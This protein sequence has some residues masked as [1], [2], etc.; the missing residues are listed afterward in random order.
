M[1]VERL[2]ERLRRWLAGLAR[3]GVQLCEQRA[4]ARLTAHHD[5]AE[6]ARAL[7]VQCLSA[8]QRDEFDR[9]RAFCVKGASG[10]RYRLGYSVTANI[11]VLDA[12]GEV[13]YRLCAGPDRMPTPAV[14]LTQ[15]LML[16]ACEAEFLRIAARHPA[17]IGPFAGPART[18]QPAWHE[19]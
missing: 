15:K 13:Q 14:L 16:E 10:R 9:T 19:G 4:R 2:G 8:A 3:A 11:E 18:L 1:R 6:R 5:A 12:A 17:V 7:L